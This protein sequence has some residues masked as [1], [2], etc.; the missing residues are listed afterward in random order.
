[1][2]LVILLLVVMSPMLSMAQSSKMGRLMDVHRTTRA[3]SHSDKGRLTISSALIR[4]AQN[5][6]N[7]NSCSF[8]HCYG[9]ENVGIQCKPSSSQAMQLAADSW[10]EEKSRAPRSFTKWESPR[11]NSWGHYANMVLA[12][13]GVST[14]IILAQD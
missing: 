12:K 14:V 3:K 4:E 13:N 6:N 8:E 7:E 1:M 2:K 9:T 5:C 10:A 11:D